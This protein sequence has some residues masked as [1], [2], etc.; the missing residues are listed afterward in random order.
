MERLAEAA[1]QEITSASDPTN[2][3]RSRA[4]TQHMAVDA[5]E[6]QVSS[7]KGYKAQSRKRRPDETPSRYAGPAASFNDPSPV[8]AL[9]SITQAAPVYR[10]EQMEDEHTEPLQKGQFLGGHLE[11]S[12]LARKEGHD[13][14]SC[15]TPANPEKDNHQSGWFHSVLASNAAGDVVTGESSQDETMYDQVCIGPFTDSGKRLLTSFF[16]MQM[17]SAI[18]VATTRE[19]S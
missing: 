1:S 6:L 15:Q 2:V 14:E 9:A 4:V 7:S 3:P 8:P 11:E 17:S 13:G 12:P 10:D 5:S 19:S 16:R 18:T